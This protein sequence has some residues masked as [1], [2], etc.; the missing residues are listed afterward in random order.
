MSLPYGNCSVTIERARCDTERMKRTPLRSVIRSSIGLVK[1]VSTSRGAK[2]LVMVTTEIS[3]LG[4]YGI[5]RIGITHSA[6][7]IAAATRPTYSA[8]IANGWASAHDGM[9]D[10]TN[11]APLSFRFPGAPRRRRRRYAFRGGF[12]PVQSR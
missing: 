11:A 4:T 5:M 8:A 6:A 7:P 10:L 9:R 2:P 1:Y 12:L 3:G